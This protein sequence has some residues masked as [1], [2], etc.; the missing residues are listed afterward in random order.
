MACAATEGG[1]VICRIWK[2]TWDMHAVSAPHADNA[3]HVR[4]DCG[5]LIHADQTA[6]VDALFSEV[7]TCPQCLSASGEKEDDY[8]EEVE[9]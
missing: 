9:S 6:W 5:L 2:G 7:V 8:D 1:T 3:A 4:T